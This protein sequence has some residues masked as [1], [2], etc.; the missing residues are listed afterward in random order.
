MA[1]ASTI[2]GLLLLYAAA[3]ELSTV[4]TEHAPLDTYTL[5]DFLAKLNVHEPFMFRDSVPAALRGLEPRLVELAGA[6]TAVNV[7]ASDNGFTGP[8]NYDHEVMFE[9][10]MADLVRLLQLKQHHDSNLSFYA[11]QAV[12]P[13]GLR[14]Y[15]TAALPRWLPF[16]IESARLW[17]KAP[18]GLG[19]AL[20]HRDDN[21]NVMMQLN[22]TKTFQL[23]P[24]WQSYLVKSRRELR[25][26]AIND[27][28]R[29]RA[30]SSIPKMQKSWSS[31]GGD[32]PGRANLSSASRMIA[33]LHPG[34]ILILPKQWWHTTTHNQEEAAVA[35]NFWFHS[36]NP[37]DLWWWTLDDRHRK[38]RE[39]QCHT[40]HPKYSGLHKDT[41]ADGRLSAA[42][43]RLQKRVI[44][45]APWLRARFLHTVADPSQPHLWHTSSAFT[46]QA[47]NATSEND[48]IRWSFD[49]GASL[50]ARLVEGGRGQGLDFSQLLRM[51]ALRH[52]KN[53]HSMWKVLN[54]KYLEL[55]D[56]LVAQSVQSWLPKMLAAFEGN[57]R[58]KESLGGEIQRGLEKLD[59]YLGGNR[60]THAASEGSFW[61]LFG[62]C[63]AK[64]GLLQP[65]CEAAY[66]IALTSIQSA[67]RCHLVPCSD[68][69]SPD[70]QMRQSTEL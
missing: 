37:F 21:H 9:T 6:N 36:R 20:M 8:N 61:G 43:K 52:T 54:T 55:F 3:A 15:V 34:D 56:G 14:D 48:C 59:K 31:M 13:E 22:G 66:R 23:I 10:N 7:H 1:N 32:A 63:D 44:K 41:E 24:P 45:T 35:I 5:C 26:L 58:G 70:A 2:L 4:R 68:R 62:N 53:G 40:A 51:M 30:K 25:Y 18:G 17:I 67:V 33:T 46:V 29:W 16:P 42:R 11:A 49:A 27:H 47:T 57:I 39:E 19:Q 12:L 65:R 60:S 64:D 28:W 38:K 50:K 69:K